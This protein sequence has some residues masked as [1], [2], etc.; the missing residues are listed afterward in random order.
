MFKTEISVTAEQAALPYVDL[1][2]EGLDTM[3]T[4]KLVS[5]PVVSKCLAL[6]LGSRT[7]RK[8]SLLRTCSSPIE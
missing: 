1:V 6:T 5:R 7:T 2:F 3:C 4:V 8:S